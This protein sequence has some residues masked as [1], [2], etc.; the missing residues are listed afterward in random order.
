ML[1]AL[2][3]RLVMLGL[4]VGV[5]IPAFGQGP[6]L[7]L[8]EEAGV[9]GPGRPPSP[10]TPPP[11]P[12]SPGAPSAAKAPRETPVE[13]GQAAVRRGPVGERLQ[14]LKDRLLDLQS[15][16]HGTSATRFVPRIQLST[17]YRERPNGGGENRS[18]LRVDRPIGDRAVV[19]VDVRFQGRNTTEGDTSTTKSGLGDLFV[20]AGYRLVDRKG[21][22]LFVGSDVIFPTA[23]PDVLGRGKYQIGPGMAASI[24]L[25]EIN[26]TLFPLAQHIRSVGGDPSRREVNYSLLSLRLNTPWSPT[27]WTFV[28]PELRVD[29]QRNRKT[30]MLITGEIGR[31]LDAHYRLF[32]RLGGA[33]WGAN[34]TGGYEFL[35]QVGV[36]Y[37]F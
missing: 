30:A 31:V 18:V 24:A 12:P 23:D 36:R 22:H 32:S 25:S 4:W 35:G 10:S 21:F 7:E 9:Q 1:V 37:M 26:S 6:E 2:L 3:V 14:N 28:Q 13:A 33:A 15:A 16:A 20:R 27:W 11:S 34:V 29:W 8:P 19:R 17:E 5:E